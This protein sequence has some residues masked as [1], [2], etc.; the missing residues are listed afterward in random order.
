MV[1]EF[2]INYKDLLVPDEKL[3]LTTG[4]K[5]YNLKVVYMELV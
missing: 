1:V 2:I 3:N 4:N 5:T